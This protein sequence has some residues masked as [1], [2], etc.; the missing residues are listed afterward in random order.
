MGILTG[1]CTFTKYRIEGEEPISFRE[2]VDERLK[3]FAF[4]ELEGSTD[5]KTTGWVGLGNVLDTEFRNAYYS[6]G[7]Y[8]AF[9][10]RIDRRSVP[11]ALQKKHVLESEEKARSMTG[12]RYLSKQE[13]TEIKDMVRAKLMSKVMAVPALFDVCW[14]V[15]EK[16][17]L[18]ASL[19]PKVREDFEKLFKRT[20]EL[21]PVPFV[22]WTGLP[23]D[24]E[25]EVA[26]ARVTPASFA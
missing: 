14:C 1:T 17:L 3:K 24:P 20:F 12:R 8:L 23:V 21:D 10:L 13:R 22:P 6:V 15:S 5:E 7:D 26:L 9:S 4:T 2:F 25:L 19:A 11:A 18:L 16:W